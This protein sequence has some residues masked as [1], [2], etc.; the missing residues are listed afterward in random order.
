MNLLGQQLGIGGH[1]ESPAHAS[2]V[3]SVADT[4]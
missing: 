3:A 1:R 2:M 4:G